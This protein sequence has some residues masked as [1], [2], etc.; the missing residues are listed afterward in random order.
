MIDNIENIKNFWNT[1]PLYYGEV[2]HEVGSKEYFDKIREIFIEDLFPGKFDER[3]IPKNIDKLKVLDLGSGP[4]LY[5]RILYEYGCRDLYS[6]DL[7]PQANLLV[8]KLCETFNFK[9]VKIYN[10]N[11]ED[12][13]F[14]NEYFEHVHCSGVIHHTENPNKCYSEINR[15]LKKNGTAVIGVYYYN[16]ILRNWSFLQPLVN[17]I[18]YLQPNLKGRGRGGIF[19]IKDV[20][21]VIRVFDGDLNPKGI[22]YYK[23]E[24]RSILENYFEIEEVYLHY[25]PLRTLQLNLPKFI[26]KLL[27]KHLGFM[28]YLNC[29]KK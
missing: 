25:F 8:K 21:E 20:K 13:S 11:A 29:K 14:D 27:D 9:G 1:N 28:I 22:A 15:V 18:S 6:A 19:K 16:F 17:S 7:T 3:I 12:L 26:H 4:G 23:N 24:I 10:E 2:A 5:T